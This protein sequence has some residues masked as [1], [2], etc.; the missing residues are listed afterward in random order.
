MIAIKIPEM[1]RSFDRF[2]SVQRLEPIVKRTIDI[3]PL[4]LV[5]YYS[6]LTGQFP[7]VAII[8]Y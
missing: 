8:N 7:H 6:P 5:Q 4:Y 3:D 1:I 2:P